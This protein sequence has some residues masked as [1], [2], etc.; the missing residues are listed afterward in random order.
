MTRELL[1]NTSQQNY[2]LLIDQGL[3][4]SKRLDDQINQLGNHTVIIS[5]E[6]TWIFCVGNTTHSRRMRTWV[7]DDVQAGVQ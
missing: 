6:K 5:D 1:V 3:L 2:P 4:Q 7:M